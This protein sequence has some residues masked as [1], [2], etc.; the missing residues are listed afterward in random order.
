MGLGFSL[1]ESVGKLGELIFFPHGCVEAMQ[2]L[3][4]IGLVKLDRVEVAFGHG[5]EISVAPCSTKPEAA[6]VRSKRANPWR[7]Y[8][9]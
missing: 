7:R 2:C 6:A 8:C 4:A 3:V 1:S 5:H 9:G